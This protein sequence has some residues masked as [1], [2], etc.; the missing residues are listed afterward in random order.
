MITVKIA[1]SKREAEECFR[2]R[3]DVFVIEQH[4]PLNV[5]RDEYDGSAL[6]FLML[7]DGHAIG[8]A[9]V[10]LKDNGTSAKIGR[11]AIISSKR[12]IGLGKNLIAAIERN[13]QLNDVNKFVLDAQTN[14]LPFY[15]RMGYQVCGEEFIDA[16]IPHRRMEKKS[17][18]GTE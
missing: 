13:P 16:G 9:R 12:G 18:R 14:A 10:V 17:G 15:E 8:T 6:H 5:E 1:D 7:E 3:E 4:V 2:I 11:V